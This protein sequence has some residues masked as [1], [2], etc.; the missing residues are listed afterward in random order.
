MIVELIRV[1]RLLDE[2]VAVFGA[3][4]ELPIHMGDDDLAGAFLGGSA[5]AFDRDSAQRVDAVAFKMCVN[6]GCLFLY[7]RRLAPTG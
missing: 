7:L 2:L 3:L 1:G 4:D 5:V 6:F